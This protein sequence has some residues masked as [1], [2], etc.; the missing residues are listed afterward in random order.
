[1]A[2]VQKRQRTK[3]DGTSGTVLWCL[4]Y[5]NPETGKE[6]TET[7]RLKRDA[8]RR[9]TE[10]EASEFTASTSTSGGG[11]RPAPGQSDG[12][13]GAPQADDAGSLSEHPRCPHQPALGRGRAGPVRHA[14]VQKWV[15]DL[16]AERSAATVHKVYTVLSQV[17]GSGVK[18]GRLV[19]NVAEGIAL[20]RVQHKER[21]FLTHEQVAE[22]ADAC[23]A[24]PVN[25]YS[26]TSAADRAAYRLVVLFLAYTGLRWGELAGL[27][28]W[29]RPDAAPCVHCRDVCRRGWPCRGGRS[30]EPRA[31]R[32]SSASIPR[33]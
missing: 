20:P 2:H 9:L 32:G 30:Q 21:R 16:S 17:L 25:K 29:P 10:V 11:H 1:M 24:V 7:F 27:R 28:R 4:R 22:L 5:I 19:R 13:T 12:W 14:D 18:D 33:R 26:S 8:E 3:R 31:P 6:R 15:A 23:A